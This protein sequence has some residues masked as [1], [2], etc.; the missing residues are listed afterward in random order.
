MPAPTKLQRHLD[1]I[2]YLVG[3][4]LPVTV[5]EL[6]ERI[7][8][9]AEKWNAGDRTSQDSARRMF[10]R[11]KDELRDLGIPLKTVPYSMDYGRTE[12]EG[13][14]IERRDFYLPY[15]KLV[16]TSETDQSYPERS[17]AAQLEIYEE[18]APVALEALRRVYSLPS[19]PLLS[20]AKSAFRKLAFDLDPDAFDKQSPV[21][22]ADR[23]HSD[24]VAAQ[25]R[26]LS[27]ALLARKRVKF[28]YHGIYRGEETQR[29][30]D[31]YGLL[32]QGG[33]WYLIGYDRLRADVRVFRV[34]RMEDVVP[35]KASPNTPDYE[36]PADFDLRKYQGRQPWEL[37]EAEEQ[38]ITARVLFKFPLSLWAER[39]VHGVEESKHDNG[40]VVRLF[41]VHQTNPFL[42]WLLGLQDEVEILDPP[43]LRA[44]LRAMAARIVEAHGGR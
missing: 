27:R 36:V 1:L 25:L 37:G 35:N 24:A 29:D 19:F 2:A 43:E 44:E 20:E 3:R 7:P 32:F 38:P 28:R 12:L 34:G 30:V 14:A 33:Q 15:L 9:Y 18:D 21:L 8:A 11:D 42:R 41:T 5:D 26:L 4:R 23:P 16:R 39:N 17:R 40:D 22:F 6:M 31:G 10:E 13:Y